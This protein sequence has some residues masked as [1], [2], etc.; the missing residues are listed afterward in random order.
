MAVLASHRDDAACSVATE[1]VL[2]TPW[3]A[4]DLR[5]L[6]E[7]CR[8]VTF[9]HEQVDLDLVAALVDGGVT[10]R[11][12]PAT[13]EL[14]VD[15]ATMRSVLDEA[16]VPV[17]AYGV[18]EPGPGTADAVAAFGASHGWPLVLKSARGG[19]DG[20]GVW[21]VADLAEAGRSWP[22][23]T[24]ASSSRSW[25]GSMRSWPAWWPGAPRVRRWPGP[26]SRRRRSGACAARCGAGAPRCR[27]DRG[28]T[29]IGEQ[30]ASIAGAEGVM[31]VELSVGRTAPGQRGGDPAAQR[32]HWTMEGSA[33]PSSRTTCGPCWTCR[34][35]DRV[36]ASPRGQRERLRRRGR[37]GS[38]RP[39]SPRPWR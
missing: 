12:G 26:W 11:P 13:L 37:R 7:R 6:A 28:G 29:A 24:V 4:S 20:K 2:G 27:G 39:A 9:D 25:S 33:P 32:G 36:A 23:S 17:P 31:A 5:A 15:K 21:T 8:V 34:W 38:G 10:V 30:V 3:V 22:G 35:D 14:A 16:G 19:Y 18:V 1:V